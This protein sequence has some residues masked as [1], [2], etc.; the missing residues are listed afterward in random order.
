MTDISDLIRMFLIGP[1]PNGP[2]GGLAINIFLAVTA[3]ASGFVLGLFL[4]LGRLSKNIV[5][6]R[7]V[8]CFIEVTRALPLLL[9]V[10]W[11]Y[12][13]VPLFAERPLPALLGAYLALTVYSAVNQA[14]IFRGGLM[15]IPAGQW[16]AA[17]STGLSHYQCMLHVILP[18][19]LRITLPSFAGFLIS[20][21]KDTS[22]VYI[23]G[24]IDL[25]LIGKSL[26]QREP[27]MFF[28]SYLLMAALY[29]IVCFAI[30]FIF[31]KWEARLKNRV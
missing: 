14:E 31:K 21:F 1:Y 15:N 13:V 8:T 24:I 11:L 25:T 7:I 2:I 4:A 26:S 20:L 27:D 5:V 12:F 22:V 6:S 9:V 17:F 30:S 3:M 18:Q 23:I 28:L 19:T 29:F 10:F 16:Q